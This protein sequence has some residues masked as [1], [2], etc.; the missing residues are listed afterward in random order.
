M[1]MAAAARIDLWAP[2]SLVWILRIY[3]GRRSFL[4][5]FSHKLCAGT[6]PMDNT[7]EGF[8]RCLSH[9]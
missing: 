8:K 2:S 9:D 5:A 3:R 1:Q 7:R 6:K 4:W